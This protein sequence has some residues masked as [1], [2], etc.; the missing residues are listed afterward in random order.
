MAR[1][2]RASRREAAVLERHLTQLPGRFV[3]ALGHPGQAF[4]VACRAVS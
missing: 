4:A 3:G 1:S 2:G